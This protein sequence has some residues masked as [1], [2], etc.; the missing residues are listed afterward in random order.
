MIK[1]VKPDTIVYGYDQKE[2]MKPKGVRIVK[3]ERRIDDSKFK[4]GKILEGLG[5]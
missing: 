5:I 4:T 2:V 1:Y 3:L